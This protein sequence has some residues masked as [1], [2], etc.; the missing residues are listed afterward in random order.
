MPAEV[1]L[2]RHEFVKRVVGRIASLE[3]YARHVKGVDARRRLFYRV[4]SRVEEERAKIKEK[5][6]CVSGR[7]R[8]RCGDHER[9]CGNAA[10]GA[11]PMR[12]WRRC[13]AG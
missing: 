8:G 7:C 3:L 2:R 12:L 5:T 10:A 4:G 13:V 6:Q 9:P 1:H 11:A